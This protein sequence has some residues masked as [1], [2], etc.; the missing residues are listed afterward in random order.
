MAQYHGTA[1]E[2]GGG[3]NTAL[4]PLDYRNLPDLAF[5]V[6]VTQCERSSPGEPTP[7]KD[8]GRR[9]EDSLPQNSETFAA[10]GQVLLGLATSL[11]LPDWESM[12]SGE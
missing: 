11:L 2:T 7:I 4:I 10:V 1:F 6:E 9:S 12:C 3:T 8:D 5:C